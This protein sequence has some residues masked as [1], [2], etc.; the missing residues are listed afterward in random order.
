MGRERERGREAER[1]VN[2][3]E[4]KGLAGR[5]GVRRDTEIRGRKIKE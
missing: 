2:E 5:L 4:R 3:T 1:G